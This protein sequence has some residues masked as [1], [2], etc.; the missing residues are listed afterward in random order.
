M[1]VAKEILFYLFELGPQQHFC[2]SGI[3][4][5]HAN[6]IMLAVPLGEHYLYLEIG[7]WR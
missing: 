3:C 7:N 2:L 1:K 5:L 4:E 6:Q